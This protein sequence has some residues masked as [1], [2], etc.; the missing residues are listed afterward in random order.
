MVWYGRG[1]ARH[2]QEPSLPRAH[3]VLRVL[4]TVPEEVKVNRRMRLTY[5]NTPYAILCKDIK[6][7][8][9]STYSGSAAI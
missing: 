8:T 3:N 5:I 4:R 7:P 1:S 2:L 9:Y 6:V